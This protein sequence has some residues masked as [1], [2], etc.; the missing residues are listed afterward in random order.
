MSFLSSPQRRIVLREMDERERELERRVARGDPDAQEALDA[1]R[2]RMGYVRSPR[3]PQ[4]TPPLRDNIRKL[5]GKAALIPFPIDPQPWLPQ[6]WE[7]SGSGI[8]PEQAVQAAERCEGLLEIYVRVRANN[9]DVAGDVPEVG[10]IFEDGRY[11]SYGLGGTQATAA[12]EQAADNMVGTAVADN[13]EWWLNFFTN[14]VNSGDALRAHSAN[15]VRRF[16]QDNT[17]E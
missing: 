12:M 2:L 11:H 5:R 6:S 9:I 10:F 7:F 1:H 3:P 14:L 17:N 8:T 4:V 13:R 16:P 15:M